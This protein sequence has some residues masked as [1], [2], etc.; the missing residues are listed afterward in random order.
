MKRVNTR[1][2]QSANKCML[3]AAVVYDVKK[4]LKWQSNKPITK[5]QE[6]KIMT[7][8][9]FFRPFIPLVLQELIQPDQSKY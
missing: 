7:E 9:A 4:L 3:M 8:K 1:G 6:M 2:I 5:I